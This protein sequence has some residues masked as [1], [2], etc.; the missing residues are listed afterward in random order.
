MALVN[1]G[2]F[3]LY[4]NEEILKKNL[5]LRNRWSNFEIILQ[6]SG[7]DISGCPDCPILG[8]NCYG[9]D[10]FTICEPAGQV[11]FRSVIVNSGLYRRYRYL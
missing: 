7:L 10:A 3:A 9:Q 6:E 1:G 4:R 11:K 8:R 5:L 2:F